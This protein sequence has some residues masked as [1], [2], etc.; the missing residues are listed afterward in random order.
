MDI[1]EAITVLIFS[2][3]GIKMAMDAA[4]IE[5]IVDIGKAGKEA[6][7]MD[8]SAGAAV[9]FELVKPKSKVLMVKK[10]RPKQTA[11]DD[12]EQPYGI[13]IERLE[14]ITAL[15]LDSIRPLPP[16]LSPKGGVNAFWG[17]ALKDDEVLLLVE[18]AEAS[19]DSFGAE[20]VAK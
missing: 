16:L 14:E 8:I 9:P 20:A 3:G 12:K 19:A 10:E 4:H 7:L 6:R 13:V 15:G 17:A 2:S 1:N 5:G 18:P 11:D